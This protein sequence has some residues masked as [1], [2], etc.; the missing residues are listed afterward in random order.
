M[1]HVMTMGW[2]LERA[3][4]IRLGPKFFVVILL[5]IGLL[6]SFFMPINGFWFWVILGIS[7]CAVWGLI[8][9][10]AV[11]A[12]PHTAGPRMLYEEEQPEVVRQIMHVNIATE[13]NGTQVYRGQ[14]VEDSRAAFHRLQEAFSKDF[15]PSIQEDEKLGERIVLAPKEVPAARHSGTQIAFHLLLM[16]LTIG[17]ILIAGAAQKNVNLMSNP[18]SIMVGVPYALAFF[19]VLAIHE[20]GHVLMARYRGVAMSWPI[21]IPVPLAFGT[22]GSFFNLRKPAPNRKALFDV[23]MAGPWLGLIVSFVFLF[24][25]LKSST[26]VLEGLNQNISGI[27]VTSSFLLA[28]ITKLALGNAVQLGH[29][30]QLSPL[31]FAGWL[32]LFVTALNFAPVG[33]LDGGHLVRALF[34][35]RKGEWMGAIFMWLLLIIALVIWPGLLIWAVVLFFISK[36]VPPPLDDVTPINPLRKWLGIASFGLLILTIAPFPEPLWKFVTVNISY[37]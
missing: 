14:L 1:N 5:V 13:E 23:A 20:L 28:L 7:S 10:Y 16:I 26:L 25:G 29:V 37:I 36:R 8:S 22:F 24:F 32:G 21:F 9:R 27:S 11:T 6:L 34:G 3:A 33:S 19:G 30:I 15:I 17:T 31:A 18:A 35:T 2:G 12:H 4:A